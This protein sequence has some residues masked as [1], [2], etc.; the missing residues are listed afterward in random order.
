MIEDLHGTEDR[1]E[2]GSDKLMNTYPS[3]LTF[4]LTPNS[5]QNIVK[6]LMVCVLSALKSHSKLVAKWVGC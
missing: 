2:Y 6:N 4:A 3:L 5:H 1:F